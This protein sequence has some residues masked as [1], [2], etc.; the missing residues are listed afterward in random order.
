MAGPDGCRIRRSNLFVF[1]ERFE[2]AGQGGAAPGT[3]QLEQTKSGEAIKLRR[4]RIVTHRLGQGR[5][6]LVAVVGAAHG[7]EVDHHGAGEVA[8]PQL[9]GNGG[10]RLEIDLDR[11]AWRAALTAAG[12]GAVD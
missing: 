2:L 11:P 1:L 6:D 12:T 3:G 5:L 10:R 9:L 8:E 4:H 7:D